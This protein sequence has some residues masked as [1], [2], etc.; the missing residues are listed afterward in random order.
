MA[1]TTGPNA[2]ASFA[3]TPSKSYGSDVLAAATGARDGA[4]ITLAEL[5]ASR[6][7]APPGRPPSR[8]RQKRGK[9]PRPQSRSRY[10]SKAEAPKPPELWQ[11]VL[12][13]VEPP[14]PPARPQ[15][16]KVSWFTPPGDENMPVP[17]EV[18]RA[19]WTIPHLKVDLKT[20]Q[21]KYKSLALPAG[22][23]ISS[24]HFKI[25]GEDGY[26]RFWPNGFFGVA[27]RKNRLAWSNQPVD[28][29]GMKA[30]S[31]CA[32][33]LVMPPDARLRLRFRVGNHWSEIRECQWDQSGSVVH[34]VWMP[35]VQEPP[36]ELSQLVVGVEVH[37][38]FSVK[39][40]QA[41]NPS[42]WL[43]S[44]RFFQM[45]TPDRNPVREGEAKGRAV[46]IDRVLGGVKA[47]K[48]TRTDA[49]LALPSPRY[50]N[51]ADEL[52]RRPP[53]CHMQTTT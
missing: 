42:P 20:L 15:G 17:E 3:I 8:G 34:Q 5:L 31:W 2:S 39:P 25:A 35:P 12:A 40:I 16:V 10:L 33:S 49:G 24:D 19:E 41:L 32:I 53:R 29:C 26:L 18:Q 14:P 47:L 43:P 30:D 50:G 22:Q 1:A 45:P 11:E 28:L 9:S 37:Y 52:W 44:P 46:A 7:E 27:T 6:P 48:A 36:R 38:N 51:S 21:V 4:E 23:Y 13:L